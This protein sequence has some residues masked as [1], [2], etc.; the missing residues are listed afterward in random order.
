MGGDGL[1]GDAHELADQLAFQVVERDL[2]QLPGAAELLRQRRLVRAEGEDRPDL[3]RDE[4]AGERDRRADH[5]VL[6]RHHR[7]RRGVQRVGEDV[8]SGR[9]GPTM[10]RS[11]C[12]HRAASAAVNADSD[13]S[14]SP[15]MVWWVRAELL[16]MSPANALTLL[17]HARSWSSSIPGHGRPTTLKAVTT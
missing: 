2:H 3:G 15:A 10:S 4:L 12:S 14:A 1:D 13:E 7:V 6:L 9:A 16:V 5:G 17:A 8:Q 11:W